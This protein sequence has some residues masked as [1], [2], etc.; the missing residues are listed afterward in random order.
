M[1]IKRKFSTSKE[2]YSHQKR[3]AQTYKRDPN[4]RKET[5]M[6]DMHI[7]CLQMRVLHIK[8]DPSSPIKRDPFVII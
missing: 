2:G 3:P 6:R 7:E 5:Q 4:E 1:Y 8:K